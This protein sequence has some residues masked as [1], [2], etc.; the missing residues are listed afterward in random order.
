MEKKCKAILIIN[1]SGKY[2]G[3][4]KRYIT[5]FNHIA[6]ERDDYFLII[7]NKLYD[8]VIS[9]R[10][11]KDSKKIFIIKQNIRK[12]HKIRYHENYKKERKDKL[13]N[14][15]GNKLEKNKNFLGR[16]KHFIKQFVLWLLFVC[17]F[18]K[19][20]RNQHIK[21]IYSV[22]FGGIWAW[23]LKKILR[24]KLIHSYND[25]SLDS[26]NKSLFYFFDSE[27][28]ALKHADKI[29]FL[30]RDIISRLENEIGV[31]ENDKKLITPNS[32]INYDN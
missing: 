25:S 16:V 13:R 4:E 10:V 21:I 19:I 30:S 3:A 12:V 11:L 27:F 23:P 31:I 18:I 5:L 20:I 15:V 17:Q 29:D 24:I 14:F 28:W 32:F 6:V 8:T 7:N 22:W 9:D 2:G 1:L 26:I